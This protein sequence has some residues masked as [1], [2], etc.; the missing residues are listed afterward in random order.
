MKD[1]FLQLLT[2][3][4]SSVFVLLGIL[5]AAFV[6]LYKIG[7]WSERFFRQDKRIDE[8]GDMAEMVIRLDTKVD[9]IYRN[10]T[11][12]SVLTSTSPL[13][14]SELGQKIVENVGAQKILKKYIKKLTEEIED[15]SA[16]NA[17]DIQMEAMRIA[18]ERMIRFLNEEE[19]NTIKQEAF[20][21]GIITEDV[22]AVFGILLRNHV[23]EEKGLPIFDV[24][25]YEAKQPKSPS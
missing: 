11:P 6:A 2:Q 15:S 10:T 9:L 21:H 24:D 20:S 19:L 1:V 16:K 3:L 12:Q 17:Y 25:V 14:L 22:L 8:L 13:G 4:N 5:M 23:L 7:K 18:K